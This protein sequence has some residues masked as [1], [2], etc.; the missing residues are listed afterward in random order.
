MRLWVKV[1]ARDCETQQTGI[2]CFAL[3]HEYAAI[4]HIPE[5]AQGSVLWSSSRI[6]VLLAPDAPLFLHDPQDDKL[7]EV[8]GAAVAGMASSSVS[9][10]TRICNQNN[11]L[12]TLEVVIVIRKSGEIVGRDGV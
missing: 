3:H 4:H 1:P 7:A 10:V 12:S 5:F 6:I 9:L 2:A 11:R 8:E